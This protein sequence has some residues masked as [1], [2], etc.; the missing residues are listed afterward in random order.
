MYDSTKK[1]LLFNLNFDSDKIDIKEDNSIDWRDIDVSI[2]T[3]NGDAIDFKAFKNA[4]ENIQILFIQQYVQ[5]FIEN[6]T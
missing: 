3:M 4:P 1:P 5:D 2:L 6:N